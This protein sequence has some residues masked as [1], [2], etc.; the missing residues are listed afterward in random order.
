MRRLFLILLT[1]LVLLGCKKSVDVAFTYTPENPKAGQTV[2]FVNVS[3]GGEK[4]LWLF[5]DKSTS[6][7]RNPSHVFTRPGEYLVTL[8]AD[9]E[10]RFAIARTVVVGDTLPSIVVPDTINYYSRHTFE[11]S[12]Y[13][14]NGLNVEYEWEFSENAAGEDLTDGKSSKATPEVY[15]TVAGVT[16]TIRLTVRVGESSPMSVE[17]TVPITGV[18]SKVLYFVDEERRLY[19]QPQFS[20]IEVEPSYTGLTFSAD[21]SALLCSDRLFALLGDGTLVSAEYGSPITAPLASDVSYIALSGDGGLL[22]A[23]GSDIKNAGGIVYSA[24]S[25]IIGLSA[26]YNGY[27]LSTSEG[28]FDS[29]GTQL[30]TIAAANVSVDAMRQIMVYSDGGKTQVS[31][32]GGSPLLSFDAVSPYLDTTDG[33][34]YYAEG[35]NVVTRTL[36]INSRPSVGEPVV[37][38]QHTADITAVAATTK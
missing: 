20:G 31:T 26:Y 9:G 32:L 2:T 3:S 38:C 21:V 15:F 18:D 6:T 10:A 30:S 35:N 13:N 17:A 8:Q 12:V 19:R 24:T 16:E 5:G 22:W 27:L 25:T 11:A 33:L 7:Y 1:S 36:G 37:I 4:W 14:P 29:N 34:M 28:L 23:S